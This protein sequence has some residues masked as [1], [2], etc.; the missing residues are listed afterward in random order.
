MIATIIFSILF[1]QTSA[2]VLG[3]FKSILQVRDWHILAPVSSLSEELLGQILEASVKS[4]AGAELHSMHHRFKNAQ[5][6][7]EALEVGKWLETPGI[8]KLSAGKPVQISNDFHN[9]H[10]PGTISEHFAIFLGCFGHLWSPMKSL[11]I[12]TCHAHSG[13]ASVGNSLLVAQLSRTYSS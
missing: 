4:R 11:E 6:G 13:C 2:K 5:G 8:D 3:K 12:H 9:C 10:T 7:R 1:A